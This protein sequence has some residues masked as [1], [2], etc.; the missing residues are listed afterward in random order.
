[1]DNLKALIVNM[2]IRLY[3]FIVAVVFILLDV[4]LYLGY[5]IALALMG[6]VGFVMNRVS[7]FTHHP[8]H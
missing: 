8:R 2:F 6:I 5:L 4:V 7:A 3:Q 1:M